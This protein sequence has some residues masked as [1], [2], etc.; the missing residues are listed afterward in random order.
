MWGGASWQSI[1]RFPHRVVR[2]V[3]FSPNETYLVSWSP[4]PITLPAEDHPDRANIPFDESTE[5]HTIC[6]WN[7]QTGGLLRTFPPVQI[8]DDMRQ[9]WPFFKFSADEKFVAR[10]H[11]GKQISVYELPGMRLLENNSI[12]IAGV[13]DFEWAPTRIPGEKKPGA[14][15][16]HMLCYWTPEQGNSPAKVALMNIPS[17]EIVRTKNLFN[18]SDVFSTLLYS[19][20]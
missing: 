9:T 18:V 3:D 20:M 16:Q 10:L 6:V 14:E 13:R 1:Q 19:L 7:T 8:P 17:K 12:K 15:E 5:G 11:P 2:L 4:D